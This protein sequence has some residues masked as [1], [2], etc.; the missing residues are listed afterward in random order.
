MVSPVEQAGQALY[1]MDGSVDT[2][3]T[4]SDGKMLA[5]KLPDFPDRS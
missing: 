2:Y 1:A 5:I 3:Q 4:V